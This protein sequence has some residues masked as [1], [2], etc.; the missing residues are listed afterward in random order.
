VVGNYSNGTSE[1]LAQILMASF[2]NQQ[3]LEKVGENLFADT[4][5]SGNARITAAAELGSKITSGYLE[6]S[7]VDLSREFTDMIIAQRAFGANAKVITTSD[8]M[9]QELVNLKR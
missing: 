6:M 2:A 7:N 4:A 3:G 9:L 5:N 8:M 1:V